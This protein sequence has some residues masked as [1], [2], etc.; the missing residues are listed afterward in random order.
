MKSLVPNIMPEDKIIMEKLL[1]SGNIMHKY[2]IRMQTVLRRA[3]GKTVGEI[4]EGVGINR[5]TV[6]LFVNRYNC[7]GLGSLLR[8]KTR[9]SG[10]PPISEAVKNRICTAACTE[11]PENATHWS[12]RSLAKR[13]S[14]G[15]STVNHI[16]RERGIKPHLV[17]EFRFS[18]DRHFE[19]KLADVVGLYMNPPDNAVVLSVD[20]KSQIQA[21]ERSAPLLPL[22]P[23]IPAR[24]S[25]DYYR[26]GTTTLF[27]ALD[28]LTGNVKGVCKP[29]HNSKDF[30]AFL[31][32]LDKVCEDG[33][34]LHIIVDNYSAHKSEETKKYL[35]G[36]AERF[37]LRFI[38]THSSWLNMVERWF[39][40]LTNK[41]IRR[42]SWGS[43]EQLITAIKS[44]IESWNRSGR[45]FKW[46]KPADK[47]IAAVAKAKK[48]Y[49]I[50]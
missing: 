27:A 38:P 9:K 15:K 23:H 30:I 5:A 12:T 40:E 11:R 29:T 33:K 18:T 48:A 21:L 6:S 43:V 2:A 24:Q 22:G 42:E 44:Y 20:E 13:F 26:H 36:R 17:K 34:K 25:A 7:G 19:G 50:V 31:E 28:M 35:T 47:I 1:A 39:G 46:T 10:T 4:A 14:V 49:N 16:L 37:E 41:R 32:E 8:D 45:V 3:A